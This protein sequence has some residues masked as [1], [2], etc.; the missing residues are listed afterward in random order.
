MG[1]AFWLL[2]HWVDL[3]QSIGIITGFIFTAYSV[4]KDSEARK[5]TNLIAIADRHHAIWKQIYDSPSLHRVLERNV[6]LETNPITADEQR[7]VTS[8]IIHLDTV[9]RAMKA[10]MFVN[11]EGLERDINDF[12]SLPIPR[13]IWEKVKLLQNEDFVRFVEACL[14]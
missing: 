4:H 5:I 6:A 12:F 8:L 7:F 14:R 10:K 9:H 13:T 11:L 3:L 2:T 1:L